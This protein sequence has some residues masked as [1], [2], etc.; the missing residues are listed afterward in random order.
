MSSTIKPSNRL[1][2]WTPGRFQP[3]KRAHGDSGGV[4]STEDDQ[5]GDSFLDGW[6]QLKADFGS[7]LGFSNG[8][9]LEVQPSMDQHP[10]SLWGKYRIQKR[11]GRRKFGME[12]S[13][14][15]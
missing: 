5:L 2:R 3:H 10:Q 9:K 15:Q 4:I 12:E 8:K 1:Q 6:P 13:Q 14:I 11:V 7:S